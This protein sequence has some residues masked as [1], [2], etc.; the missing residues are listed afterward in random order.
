MTSC[1]L[2]RQLSHPW[3]HTRRVLSP[4]AAIET[5]VD[6]REMRR[7]GVLGGEFN[8][9]LSSA[10]QPLPREGPLAR[11]SGQGAG[12]PFPSLSAMGTKP[13]VLGLG[14]FPVIV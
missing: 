11:Q 3:E 1:S 4:A 8:R 13:G 6:A 10:R 14:S 7:R 5:T 9:Q 2:I 12:L